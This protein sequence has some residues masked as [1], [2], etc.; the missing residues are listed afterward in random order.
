MGESPRLRA[1]CSS[2]TRRAAAP[3]LMPEEF[4]AVTV[5]PFSKTGASRASDSGVTPARGCSSVA[6]RTGP[7]FRLGTSTGTSSSRKRLPARARAA[8]AWLSAAK[9]SCSSRVTPNSRA[10]TSAVCPSPMVH[11]EA[12]AGLGKRHPST[13][14]ATV[15]VP[16]A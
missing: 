12:K 13:V 14:S 7:P 8:R 3:S 1:R 2:I 6:T 9:A 15:G 11:S 16:R 4:P 10:T 5:P